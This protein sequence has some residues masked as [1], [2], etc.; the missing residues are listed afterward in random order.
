MGYSICLPHEYNQ[1]WLIVPLAARH[2]RL[3]RIECQIY[4]PDQCQEAQMSCAGTPFLALNTV[5]PNRPETP[6]KQCHQSCLYAQN[7]ETAFRGLSR[8][9]SPLGRNLPLSP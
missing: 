9:V 4:R 5:H 6:G 3:Q 1:S 2:R 7:V 8:A